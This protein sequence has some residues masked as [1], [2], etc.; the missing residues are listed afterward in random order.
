MIRVLNIIS[1]TNIG[2]AGRV[3]LNYLKYSDR[4]RFETAV[5]M[6]RGSALK[7]RVEELR[8]KVYEVDGMADRSMDLKVIG[9]LKD[10]IYK[11]KP[12]IVHTHGSLSG[13][14]AGRQCGKAVVYTR[15]S[16][17]PVKSYMKRGPGRWLNKWV[18]E[19]YADAIIAISPAA[20]QNLTDAGISP[21]KIEI[22]M[23]GVEPVR[24]ASPGEQAGFRRD[25]GLESG[26]FVTGILARV[27]DYKGHEDILEAMAKLLPAYPGLKLLVAGEGSYE[28]QVRARC[29]ALG[30]EKNVIFLG[31]V[32]DVAPVLSVLDAQLNASWGTEACSVALLEGMSMGVPAVVSDYGGNPWLVRDGVSGLIFKTRD[33]AALAERLKT[34]MDDP[35]LREK[36]S[37]GARREYQ[38]KFTGEIAAARIEQIYIKTLEASHG[39]GK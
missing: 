13:R 34:L 17:F 36:L 5:A 24:A 18:N 11:V 15:H 1:D 21:K 3:I 22:M 25:H 14:I 4:S 7:E 35:A 28:P 30:L 2:G 38:E 10:L 27:E 26:D 8:V 33:T 16:A 32:R 23:N 39:T 19:H 29:A 31:F 12:D 37:L 9:A 6:P 20:A